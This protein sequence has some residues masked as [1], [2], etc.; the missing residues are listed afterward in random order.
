MLSFPTYAKR[1]Y[2]HEK[3]VKQRENQ[4]THGYPLQGQLQQIQQGIG[5]RPGTSLQILKYR[6]RRR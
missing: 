6:H 4:G 1:R 2:G 5:D 3:Q